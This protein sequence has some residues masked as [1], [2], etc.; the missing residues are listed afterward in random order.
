[1]AYWPDTGTGVDTQPARKPVQS[2]IRKYFTEGGIG[3]APTVPGG[4]WFNQM[5]NEV[6]NV[7]E[8]AG[9]EPSKTD[10]DQ[11]SQAIHI[12]SK[13]ALV[14][15]AV[16]S[17]TEFDI[18][19]SNVFTLNGAEYVYDD[20]VTG[21][22]DGPNVVSGSYYLVVG[23]LAFKKV[24]SDRG[25][26]HINQ[27]GHIFGEDA[28]PF[29]SAAQQFAGQVEI[30]GWELLLDGGFE[31]SIPIY[32]RG[33]LKQG[34]GDNGVVIVTGGG[35]YGGVNVDCQ[36]SDKKRPLSFK[37]GS[38]EPFLDR[39]SVKNVNSSTFVFA[40]FIENAG[41]S[42]FKVRNFSVDSLYAAPSGSEGDANGV[43]RAVSVSSSSSLL[44]SDTISSGSVE[45]IEAR[46][47]ATWEDCDAIAVQ[48]I[49]SSGA[50]RDAD[51][52]LSHI[53]TREVLKRAVKIQANGVKVQDV[54]ARSNNAKP[55]YSVVSYYGSGG[56]VRCI[57]GAG[58]NNGVDIL[59]YS[60]VS[61]VDV[62]TTTTY[63]PG[64]AI[65][66]TGG[67]CVASG[68]RSNG[69]LHVVFINA[70][71]SAVTSAAFSGVK[72]SSL[73]E[74]LFIK[75]VLPVG[76]ISIDSGSELTTDDPTRY[77]V[78]EDLSAPSSVGSLSLS[79]VKLINNHFFNI[80]LQKTAKLIATDLM[81]G[82]GSVGGIKMLGGS[83]ELGGIY[84]DKSLTV[85]L[86]STNG[87]RAINIKGKLRI[88]N[89]VDT[90]AALYDSI[91]EIGTNTGLKKLS[92]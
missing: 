44:P 59:G 56:V 47:M 55:M 71:L 40:L 76:S 34:S 69:L 3:Q 33:T 24:Y 19:I 91:E 2:A 21:L 31:L 83:A 89:T 26:Y 16:S 62:S 38:T 82:G 57:R 22:P 74:S 10:D 77:A 60:T 7:L 30:T 14:P 58:V 88:R 39:V 45:F 66:I 35:L 5:T 63:E 87:S 54:D 6:L 78:A 23:G 75:P 92:W 48:C 79:N 46:N 28:S 9:I 11:L 25:V 32:G 90:S 81:C 8:A 64:G 20:T 42:N 29:I 13:S 67:S 4:D 50:T 84:S 65:Q 80:F 52:T 53:K 68:I 61:D 18:A 1:M 72:G 49:D 85:E 15:V 70:V 73:L 86:E 43:C 37:K 12:I 41:V 27:L 17:P 36:N 51:I